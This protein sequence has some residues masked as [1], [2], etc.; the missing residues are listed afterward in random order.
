MLRCSRPALKDIVCTVSFFALTAMLPPN[1][2]L[3]EEWLAVFFLTTVLSSTTALHSIQLN[4]RKMGTETNNLLSVIQG[5]VSTADY[6]RGLYHTILTVGLYFI[7]LGT[8]GNDYHPSTA[9]QVT[10]EA[11]EIVRMGLWWLQGQSEATI[12]IVL[13]IECLVSCHISKNEN[14]HLL[15]LLYCLL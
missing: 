1:C 7:I 9:N 10:T 2:L 5:F 12:L 14:T 11:P 3:S 15:R 6:T 4:D 13:Y 8:Y